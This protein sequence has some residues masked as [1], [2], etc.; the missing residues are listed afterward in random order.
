MSTEATLHAEQL[1]AEWEAGSRV[2]LEVPLSQTQLAILVLAAQQS[3]FSDTCSAPVIEQ[4]HAFEQWCLKHAA[5]GPATR[6][7]I[8]TR[9]AAL[10]DPAP[11]QTP[12]LDRN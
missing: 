7:F 9:A 1:E 6:Q 11:V 12:G 3:L 8:A 5:F 2:H 10:R 4:L